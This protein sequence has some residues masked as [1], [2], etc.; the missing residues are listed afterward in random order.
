MAIRVYRND[1]RPNFSVAP[2]VL[3]NEAAMQAIRMN[4]KWQYRPGD[5]IAFGKVTSSNSGFRRRTVRQT[6]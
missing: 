5:D 4:G 6:N 3:M 2:P 1:P